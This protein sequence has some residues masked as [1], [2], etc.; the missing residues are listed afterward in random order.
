MPEKH[1]SLLHLCFFFF[2]TFFP[3]AQHL[4]G[5]IH[6]ISLDVICLAQFLYAFQ[7]LLE[8]VSDPQILNKLKLYI[9][10]QALMMTNT[11]E[12][13]GIFPFCFLHFAFTQASDLVYHP[14]FHLNV[15]LLICFRIYGWETFWA[16]NFSNK[17]GKPLPIFLTQWTVASELLNEGPIPQKQYL[18]LKEKKKRELQSS[19][20]VIL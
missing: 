7:I 10:I 16:A 8:C 6:L 18:H 17:L 9:C 20:I 13:S 12:G 15:Y 2:C 11:T 19:L 14:Y 5:N 3:F 4:K 1:L